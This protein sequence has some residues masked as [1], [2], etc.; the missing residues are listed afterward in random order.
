MNDINNPLAGHP[1]LQKKE[2]PIAIVGLDFGAV[3]A[4][5]MAHHPQVL[6]DAAGMAREEQAT[7]EPKLD[8]FVVP[9]SMSD[10]D[11]DLI[12]K[13]IAEKTGHP[14]KVV[15]GKAAAVIK[16]QSTFAAQAAWDHMA[17][18]KSRFNDQLATALLIIK[19]AKRPIKMG[20]IEHELGTS[21]FRALEPELQKHPDVVAKRHKNNLYYT[22]KA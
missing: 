12:S 11:M 2:D 18:T 3:E 22:W 15:R 8:T 4:R 20:Y 14:F 13:K 1:L 10:A 19:G 9:A 7:E 6:A 5:V 17:A 16:Q 21:I